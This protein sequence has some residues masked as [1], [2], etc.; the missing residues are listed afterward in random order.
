MR[1]SRAY[2]H[3]LGLKAWHRNAIT[4]G[5]I[6]T[7]I[8]AWLCLLYLPLWRA[9]DDM[10][11]SI[12]Q[13]Q[14]QID[15]LIVE[16]SM[17]KQMHIDLKQMQDDLSGHKIIYTELQE[18][19]ASVMQMIETSGLMLGSLKVTDV[20]DK[21][22]YTSVHIRIQA[23]GALKAIQSFFYTMQEQQLFV[24]CTEALVENQ[25]EHMSL[26]CIITLF[27]PHEFDENK[28]PSTLEKAEGLGG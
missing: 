20:R 23:Q 22:W 4:I 11:L 18:R 8:L 6:V 27:M 10:R 24:Q 21:D 13:R 17:V 15:T 2:A 1:Y 9:Y 25:Q 28:S 3:M 26:N 19:I 16:Q 5:I 12:K 14:Q 7:L